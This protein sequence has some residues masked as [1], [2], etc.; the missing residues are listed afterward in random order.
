MENSNNNLSDI[1]KA[2]DLIKKATDKST[3]E[4]KEINTLNEKISFFNIENKKHGL[5]L[6]EIKKRL[7]EIKEATNKKIEFYS[8]QDLYKSNFLFDEFESKMK[9]ARRESSN[10]MYEIQINLSK[11][12]TSHSIKE[13]QETIKVLNEI[14]KEIDPNKPTLLD[15][16]ES[17]RQKIFGSKN[18]STNKIK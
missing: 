14:A 1:V 13:T 5:P 10:D 18:D 17:F 3:Q 11:L 12:L 2:T 8:N 7:T 16:M 6:D 4:I 9:N 15:K